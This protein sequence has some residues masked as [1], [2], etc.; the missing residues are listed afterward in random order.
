VL[1]TAHSFFR[2]MTPQSLQFVEDYYRNFAVA[3]RTGE[4][5]RFNDVF[6]YGWWNTRD[7]V[8]TMES[9]GASGRSVLLWGEHAWSYTL[10]DIRP[11]SRFLVWY[12]VLEDAER[13][14]EAVQD[15]QSAPA[16]FIVIEEGLE[17]FPGLQV[18]IDE[19]YNCDVDGRFTICRLVEDPAPTAANGEQE[20]SSELPPQPP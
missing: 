14:N 2:L 5:D 20:S 9:A 12:H 19:S 6:T 13:E 4:R 16:D 1:L 18:L 10:A 17:P 15:A 7:L 3:M 8:T 11:V